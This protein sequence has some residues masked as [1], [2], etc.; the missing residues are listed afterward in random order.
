MFLFSDPAQCELAMTAAGF[1]GYRVTKI[2]QTWRSSSGKQILDFMRTGTVRTRGML[3]RQR[4]EAL[5]AINDAI[6]TALLPFRTAT[7]YAV[8]MPAVLAAAT[9]P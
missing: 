1:E 3:L 5:S 6:L 2:P 7:G 8:P 4:P 9:K